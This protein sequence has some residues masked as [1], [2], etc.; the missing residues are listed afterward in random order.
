MAMRTSLVF[1]FALSSIAALASP[2]FALPTGAPKCALN[3]QVV[4]QGHRAAS[5]ANLG[6]GIRVSGPVAPNRPVEFTVTNKNGFP[7]YNGILIYV[8]GQNPNIH[9]GKFVDIDPLLHRP[10]DQRICQAQNLQGD[11]NAVLTHRH[12]LPKPNARALK[13]VMTEQDLAADPGPYKIVSAFAIG[14]KMWQVAPQV[15]LEVVGAPAAGTNSTP[16]VVMPT[17]PGAGA[18]T[19]ADPVTSLPAYNSTT[20]P[21]IRVPNG[22][23]P[24]STTVATKPAATAPIN[25]P[26]P[27]RGAGQTESAY[28]V[29]YSRRK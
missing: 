1:A 20:Q 8:Q 29:R 5:N 16:P 6:Y 7:F 10:Q 23:S 28:R 11:A 14:P 17:V 15:T 19:P 13:W 4:A 22:G 18:G 26:T 21:I 3:E 12:P 24:A 25:T 9:I 27:G 2:S